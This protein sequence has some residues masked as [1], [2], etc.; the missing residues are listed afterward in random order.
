MIKYYF[1]KCE[2]KIEEELPI[3]YLWG[4]NLESQEKV[5]FKVSG[6]E[7]YFYVPESAQVPKIPQIKRVQSGFKSIFGEP[8]K[9]IVVGIPDDIRDIKSN[10]SKTFEA[11]LKY[12][13]RFLINLGIRK[14]FSVP[15]DKTELKYTEIIGE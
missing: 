13:P 4:R 9:K 10:F 2:Y 8:C 3:I 7:H 15:N 14:Y 6:F 11:D 12:I 1:I 5:I